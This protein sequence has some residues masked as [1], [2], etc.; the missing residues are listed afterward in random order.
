MKIALYNIEYCSGL[1][2][3]IK[4][5]LFKFWRY[6][7]LSNVI[8][9]KI[10]RFLNT[11]KA[12]VVLLVE[13][14]GGSARNGFKSQT[15]EISDKINL[16]FYHSECKYHPESL[17]SKL[18][19]LGNNHNSI[20]SKKKGEIKSHYLKS[21][22]KKLVQ[23]YITGGI[24]IFM[25]HLSLSKKVRSKQLKEI[26]AILKKCKNSYIICGDFNVFR[27]TEEVAEFMKKNKL[28]L[29]E[30][31]ATFPSVD[32]IKQLDLIMAHKSIKFK[33]AKVGTVK[34]SDHLPVVVEVVR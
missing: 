8:L 4:Q 34:Y 18:P 3:S 26:S 19:F 25:A 14:D 10:C 21:G 33:S 6:L 23:E 5:Y 28:H 15:E 30:T 22:T 32:P 12:D 7:W 9:K 31:N 20:L 17:L 27:G 1:D 2:G 24:S 13:V 16:P 11:L 29:A